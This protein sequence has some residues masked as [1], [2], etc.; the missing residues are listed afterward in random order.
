MDHLAH[1]VEWR[2]ADEA[3]FV[4]AARVDGAWWVLRRNSFPDHPLYTLFVDGAVVGDVE[5]LGTRAP[6]WDL[7]V[8]GRPALTGEQRAEA[9]S[10]LRGFGPY[11]SEVGR[12]CDGDWCCARRA[13]T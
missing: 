1:P 10:S 12:P 7:D 2:P 6:A 8:A 4:Y 13:G 9:L 5:D 3:V 11:G